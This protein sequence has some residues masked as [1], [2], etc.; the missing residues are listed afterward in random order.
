[1]DVGNAALPCF[2]RTG[3]AIPE[4]LKSD[5]PGVRTQ[6]CRQDVHQCT[7]A[8]A[9]LAD[10]GVHFSPSHVEIYVIESQ[11]GSKSF[12]QARDFEECCFAHCR[13]LLSGG[14]NSCWTSAFSIFSAVTSVTP[15]SILFSTD[16][17]CKW[18]T[19]VLTP[20]SPIRNGFCTTM[21]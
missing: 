6:R 1:M 21:P 7:F 10:D 18:S 8:C 19:M 2:Q 13:Y 20:R 3:W 15:V 11:R 14:C 12:L 4:P 5:R 9:V 17:P 16:L